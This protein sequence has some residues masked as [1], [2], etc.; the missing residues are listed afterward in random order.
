MRKI[1]KVNYIILKICLL[2]IIGILAI[3]TPTKYINHFHSSL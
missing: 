1:K 2:I 3:M